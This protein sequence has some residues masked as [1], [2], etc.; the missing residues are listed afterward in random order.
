MGKD[1]LLPFD[2]PSVMRKKVS[3]AFD[4]GLLSSDAGVLLL[5][6]VEKKLGLAARLASCIREWRKPE[7]IVHPLEDMLRLRMF[8]IAAGYEDGN[9]CD[10]LRHDPIFKM[11]VGH[12]RRAAILCARSPPCRGWR[13]RRRRSRLRG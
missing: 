11:A 10:S 9:D 13:M 1:T 2:L 3:V 7:A 12:A 4:G 5:R 6:E 8:A